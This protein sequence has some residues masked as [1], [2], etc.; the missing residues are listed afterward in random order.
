MASRLTKPWIPIA[1]ADSKLKG[2]MGVF[3]LADA[4]GELIYMGF[5]G[6]K[7]IYGLRG[8]VAA[9]SAQFDEA[10]SYRIEITT[11]YMTRFRELMMVYIADNGHPPRLNPPIKLGVLSPG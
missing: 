3:Q 7:S 5:A 9:A 11:S 8:E 6:G 1:E 10:A 4:Q 2:H